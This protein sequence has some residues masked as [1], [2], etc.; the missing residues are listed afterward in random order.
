MKLRGTGR[1]WVATAILSVGAI[2]LAPGWVWAYDYQDNFSTNKAAESGDTYYHSIFWPEGAYPPSDRPYLYYQED[3]SER[4]LGFEGYHGLEASLS[5]RFPTGSILPGRALSGFLHIDLSRSTSTG[6][7]EYELSADGVNWE[8][9]R[10]LTPG[11]W[12]IGLDS[13]R[14]TCYVTFYGSG[15]LIDN[16]SVELSE[17]PATIHVPGDFDTI[18]DA[19]YFARNGDIVEVAPDTY[20]GDGNWDIDFRG[21]AITVRSAEGPHRTIIDCQGSHRAFYFQDFEDSDSVLRGFKII[22]GLASGSDIPS[23]NSNWS[24]SPTHPVGGGIY[25]EFSSPTI[26][27]CIIEDCAAEVGGGIGCVD[28]SPTIIDCVIEDCSAGGHGTS[29]TG[30]FGGGIGIIRDSNVVMINCTIKNNTGHRESLGGGVYCWK[31]KIQM[32]ECTIASNRASGTIK[33]G[34]FYAGGTSSGFSWDSDIILKNCIISK[35]TANVGGGVFIGSAPWSGSESTRE[36]VDII[37]CTIAHNNHTGSYSDGGGIHSVTSS[38]AIRNSIVWGNGGQAVKLLSPSMSSPVLF[39]DIQGGYSGQGNIN[40]DPLFASSS[41]NDYHLKS[42]MPDGR[43]N[44]TWNRWEGD[45]YHSPCIDAGDP[46]DSVHAEPLPNGKR[47]INMGAYGGTAEASKGE[48]ATIY[49]VDRLLG[50]DYNTGVSRSEAFKTIGKAVEIVFEGDI[51]M[52]WPGTYREEVIVRQQSL[53]IQ[54]AG[55]AAVVEA[56]NGY[57]FSF[58]TAES[59]DSVLRNFVITGCGEAAIYCHSASPTLA[60]LTITD[61]KFGIR[62]EGGANPDIVNCIIWGNGENKN[63]DIGSDVH[64]CRPTYSCVEQN[65]A[66]TVGRNNIYDDPEFADS[67]RGDYHLLSKYGRYSP[68]TETWVYDQINSPCI[69]AG[70]ISMGPAREQKP[71]GSRINIGAYGGTP[72]ASQSRF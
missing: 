13:V 41:G 10:Q 66:L 4:K 43:Y 29:T 23:D 63:D 64:N 16:L 27:D 32:T 35:N 71:N 48:D 20:S 69:D 52:V 67:E 42:W 38:I 65:D 44:S 17:E 39:S 5:Y 36:T 21:R 19:I 46:Q 50:S 28:A 1:F 30:G 34:G 11:S 6:Y 54:S 33:G 55:D 26:I 15:V 8:T 56:P 3:G 12:D 61:N 53:T 45:N 2:F 68:D 72:Y 7:L 22:N 47:R 18:Q 14:G 51:I 24:P 70:D 49:H 40:T 59:S 57:A 9:R 62:A 37:N 31:S 60:N 58:F 25:C